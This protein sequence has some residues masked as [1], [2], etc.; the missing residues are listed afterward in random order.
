MY[1]AYNTNGLAF[2]PLEDALSLIAEE[3]FRGV[4]LTLD[5]H[6][7]DPRDRAA[8]LRGAEKVRAMLERLGLRATIETGARFILDSR[9]KHQPTLISA[10]PGA[11][12]RRIKLLETAVLVCEALS[13]ECVSL[14]SGAAD[15]AAP[16]SELEARLAA[17]LKGLLEFAEPRGVRLAFEPEPGMFVET[18][19]QYERLASAIDHPRFGLTLDVNH[20]HCL[21]DGDF[22]EHARRHAARLWNVHVSDARRGAHEHLVPGEG[23]VD[24][25]AIRAALESVS[26]AGPFQLELSRH[27]HDAVNVMRAAL[28]RLNA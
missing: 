10:D 15:V 19:A 21:A 5:H 17:G 2:H 14:W 23:E 3:G 28:K 27:G 4:G 9:R 11:R 8:A 6:H 13:A 16:P 12:A 7:L 25:R 20:V 22:G 24:F 26:Y 18:V 1:P